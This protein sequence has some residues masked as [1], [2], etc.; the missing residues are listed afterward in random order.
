MDKENISEIK[1]KGQQVR[2]VV[3]VTDSLV[4]KYLWSQLCVKTINKLNLHIL[5]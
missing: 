5:T 2:Q 1:E 3:L 4:V